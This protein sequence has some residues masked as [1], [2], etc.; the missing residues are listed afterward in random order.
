MDIENIVR[1]GEVTAVDNS[2]HIAKVWFDALKI[3]SDWMPVLI[4]RDFISGYGSTQRT[5]YEQGGSGDAAFEAHKHDLN[6][7]PYMPVV[8]ESVLVLY[9]PVFNGDGVILGGVRPWR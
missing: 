8:H 2:K 6:I 4:N 9:I 5:E 7:H 3:E 1:V